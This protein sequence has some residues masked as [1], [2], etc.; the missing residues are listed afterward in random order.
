VAGIGV[1]SLSL[2]NRLSLPGRYNERLANPLTIRPDVCKLIAIFRTLRCLGRRFLLLGSGEFAVSAATLQ[3]PVTADAILL[4]TAPGIAANSTNPV[5]SGIALLSIFAGAQCKD[6][7]VLYRP[8]GRTL[9]QPRIRIGTKI[10]PYEHHNRGKTGAR[11]V[12]LK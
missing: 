1:D 5:D 3:I 8:D 9:R 6:K 11:N 2:N 12:D 10:S 7:F 4:E